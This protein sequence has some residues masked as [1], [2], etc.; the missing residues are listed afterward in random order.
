MRRIAL[1]AIVAAASLLIAQPSVYAKE[2]G[3]RQGDRKAPGK[4]CMMMHGDRMGPGGPMFGDPE[5]MKKDLGLTDEQVKK[6][7]GINSE[8]KKKMLEYREK[9]APREIQLERLLLEDAVDLA[10]VKSLLREISD[11]KVEVQMLRIQHRLDI[12]KVLTA[13]QK[14]KMRQHRKHMMGKKG[15]GPKGHGPEGPRDRD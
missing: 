11:L 4:E 7:A 13:E 2:G 15:H 10:K 9:L 3:H 1:C 5:R 8:H 14:E 6:I 12:E